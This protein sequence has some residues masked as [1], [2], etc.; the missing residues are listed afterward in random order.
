MEN[1]EGKDAVLRKFN[2]CCRDGDLVMAQQLHATHGLSAEDVSAKDNYQS[3]GSKFS[4]STHFCTLIYGLVWAHMEFIVLVLVVLLLVVLALVLISAAPR[5]TVRGGGNAEPEPE[6]LPKLAPETLQKLREVW[7]V[8][9][10]EKNEVTGRV[11]PTGE[12]ET[13]AKGHESGIPRG[14]MRTDLPGVLFHTHPRVSG[15]ECETLTP[16]S[17]ND[18]LNV[19]ERGRPEAVVTQRGVWM[20]LPRAKLD[21]YGEVSMVRYVYMLNAQLEVPGCR[22]FTPLEK[23][24]ENAQNLARAYARLLSEPDGR[25]FNGRCG[26]EDSELLKLVRGWYSMA[27]ERDMSDGEHGGPPQLV[28]RKPLLV[29]WMPWPS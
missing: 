12:V 10:D 22:E 11:L 19:I 7:E 3:K 16:P 25:V 4:P 5:P 9:A 1:T 26:I 18:I 6:T 15:P 14:L 29:E 20:I 28:Q 2:A 21:F 17:A 13:D 8:A 23:E 24:G 27:S